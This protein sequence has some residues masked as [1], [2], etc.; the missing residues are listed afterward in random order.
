MKRI[1]LTIAISLLI[2]SL[3]A[4]IFFKTDNVTSQKIA[5][6]IQTVFQNIS[7]ESSTT[8]IKC[9]QVQG[10]T[11]TLMQFDVLQKGSYDDMMNNTDYTKNIKVILPMGEQEIH[12]VAKKN[13]T[14]S[15]DSFQKI[16]AEGVKVAV[17]KDGLG[18]ETTADVIKQL[19]GGRWTTVYATDLSDAT[20]KLIENK[21]DAFFY[22]GY[23]PC[24]GMNYFNT[25]P[26]PIQKN[27]VLLPLNDP[28]LVGSYSPITIKAN[29]YKWAPYDVDTY[30]VKTF[31]VTS[32]SYESSMMQT[33]ALQMLQSIKTNLSKLSSGT[34][35]QAHIWK[36]VKFDYSNANWGLHD[37]VKKVGTH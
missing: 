25:L 4:Q 36:R 31:L 17:V 24:D 13:S 10:G 12:L 22:V 29:T 6:D 23:T 1:L 28:E 5:E 27:I 32:T 9:E 33:D 11:V 21:I 15:I 18:T 14:K 2:H 20:R 19:S 26:F 16:K 37:I 8:A 3:Q 35:T 34:E 7:L 30:S